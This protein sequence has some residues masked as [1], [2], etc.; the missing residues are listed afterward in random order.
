MLV[1]YDE[2]NKK[3]KTRTS[4]GATI[5]PQAGIRL[6]DYDAV[7]TLMKSSFF[8]DQSWTC[9]TI[10]QLSSIQWKMSHD[11]MT[12]NMVIYPV[13]NLRPYGSVIMKVTPYFVPEGVIPIEQRGSILDAALFDGLEAP[14]KRK[15][16]VMV[17]KKKKVIKMNERELDYETEQLD[18]DIEG[19]EAE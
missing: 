12:S 5:Y 3:I 4:E 18:S 17:S 14:K 10:V 9:K 8:K 19:E 15:R 1:L 2:N 16:V 6:T 13:F 7:S 11:A